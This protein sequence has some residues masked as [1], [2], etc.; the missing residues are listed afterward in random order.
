MT[1]LELQ[2]QV[3]KDL[4]IDGSELTLAAIKTPDLH[5]RYNKMLFSEKLALKKLERQFS[6]LYLERWEYYR[7]KAPDEIYEKKPLLKKIMDSDVKLYLNADDEIQALQA[8]IDGKE[9]LIDFLKRV[10]DNVVMRQW[11]IKAAN[12]NNKYLS[13][14]K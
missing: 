11:L 7:K 10:M 8:Q 5:N 9:E 1:L 14:E 6:I 2:E 13:G 4:K 3:K 12:D